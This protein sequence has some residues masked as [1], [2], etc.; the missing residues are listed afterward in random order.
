MACVDAGMAG[1][2]IDSVTQTSKRLDDTSR[3]DSLSTRFRQRRDV[4]LR[5][6]IS[7]IAAEKKLIRILDLGGTVEYWRRVGVEF[8]RDASAHVTVLNQLPSE[9]RPEGSDKALFATAV[10]DACDLPQF[11]DGAFDLVHSNSV[12]EH[13]GNWSRMKSFAAET[14]RVG[15]SYYVQTP[16][17][18]FPI[19]PHYY[20]APMIHWMPRP[21]QAR[22]LKSFP[23][24]YCGRS[25]SLDA[26]YEILDSTQL[27]DGQ[28]FAQLFPDAE[29]TGERILGLTK[30]LMAI[31][32]G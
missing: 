23:V 7:Q 4:R 32:R 1:S 9:L 5:D 17:Y 11:G 28:Q 13:V 27:I 2:A 26:S 30:S 31:R 24:A 19:D 3:T 25:G 15:Q 20:R 29:I 8:L 12:V 18:W 6:L 16:Y 21:W 14:R 10:G 22:I